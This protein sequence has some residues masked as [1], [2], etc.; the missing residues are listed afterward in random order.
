MR[1]HIRVNDMIVKVFGEVKDQVIDA[2]LLGHS[3]RIVDVA[4]RAATGVALATPQ[5]QRHAHHVVAIAAQFGGSHRRIDA[6][7]HRH[8]HFHDDK[9]TNRR[10]LLARPTTYAVV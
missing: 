5:P 6:T 3:S 10:R 9:A 2:Q 4:H 7:R 1:L 8:E